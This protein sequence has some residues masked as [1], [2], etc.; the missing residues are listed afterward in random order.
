[1]AAAGAKLGRD[2]EGGSFCNTSF[3]ADAVPACGKTEF[4]GGAVCTLSGGGTASAG[5]TTAVFGRGTGDVTFSTDG[6][7][8]GDF[9]FDLDFGLSRIT[10]SN[11]ALLTLS[12]SSSSCSARSITVAA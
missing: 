10:G 4:D 12:S 2:A 8:D 3:V 9:D 5:L 1:M 6:S 7:G 11:K